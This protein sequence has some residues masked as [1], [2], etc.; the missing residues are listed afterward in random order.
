MSR[1]LFELLKTSK[2][3]LKLHIAK[4]KMTNKF[5]I[6]DKR[7]APSLPGRHLGHSHALFKPFKFE[8]N[9][10]KHC[11]KEIRE[12]LNQ[13]I[14]AIIVTG[15]TAIERLELTSQADVVLMHKPIK[16]ADLRQQI[17]KYVNR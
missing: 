5:K 15:D 6:W 17:E 7:T 12:E 13:D 8:D 10:E 4:E 9:F 1:A 16:P 2:D 3:K 14:P 11:I